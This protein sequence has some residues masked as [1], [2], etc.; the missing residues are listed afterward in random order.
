MPNITVIILAAGQGT[1]MKS[2]LTKVLHPLAGRPLIDYS[3]RCAAELSSEKP[4]VVV[5]NDAD[6]V[7]QFVGERAAFAVQEPQLGTAHAVLAAKGLQAGKEG[8]VLTIN[9]DMPLLT[10]ETL[11]QLVKVQSTN[12]GPITMLTVKGEDS[13]GFGRVIRAADGSVREIVEEAHA[14]PEQLA[15]QEYNVSAYCFSSTWLWP[16]LKRVKLSPK[17]E[18][19]LTDLVGLAVSDGLAVQAVVLDDA[20]EAVGINTRVHL[21]EAEAII[22]RRINERWMLAGVTLVDPESV[23][24]GA[25]VQIGKDTTIWPNTYLRGKTTI[26]E[27][28]VVGPNTMIED[29]QIGS[30]CTLLMAVMEGA[31]LEDNV[32][33]GPF[34]HL[35]KGAHLANGVHM[36]NFGEVKNSYLG[37]ETKMGHFSYIGDATIG[38]NV[39]IGAGTVTCNFDGKHKNHT[40]IGDDVFIGS[41]TMLVA[42]LKIGESARTGAGSVVTHDV[43]PGT[44]VVGVPARELRKVREEEKPE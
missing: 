4:V 1:R 25:D 19:Y 8:L 29:T 36:G 42:P 32:S 7:R 40:D 21:A 16:A 14:T 3:L 43:P 18:Y 39:N 41:D 24:I 12:K 38:E 6:A 5:G 17:G 33:M 9:A 23:F 27:G 15:I 10:S 28:C 20:Q 11:K 26:G 30:H 31:V 37:P 35:R 22:R 34:A 13:H 44:V 2:N